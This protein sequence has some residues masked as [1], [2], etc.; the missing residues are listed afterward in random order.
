MCVCHVLHYRSE[1]MYYLGP[2]LSQPDTS[3]AS[4]TSKPDR[5]Q[6]TKDQNL[7]SEKVWCIELLS[8]AKKDTSKF[9]VIFYEK[10]QVPLKTV[11]HVWITTQWFRWYVIDTTQWFIVNYEVSR[12][13]IDNSLFSFRKLKHTNLWISYEQSIFWCS[14]DTNRLCALSRTTWFKV[15]VWQWSKPMVFSIIS[16]PRSSFSSGKVPLKILPL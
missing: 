9:K 13:D 3:P 11:Q 12:P 2:D 5:I 14:H 16:R 15:A 8:G 4:H 10:F 6:F 7:S 1:W